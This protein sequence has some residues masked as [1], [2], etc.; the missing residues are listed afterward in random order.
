MW[1]KAAVCAILYGIDDDEE[2]AG[3]L[4][5]RLK[6]RDEDIVKAVTWKKNPGLPTQTGAFYGELGIRAVEA[7]SLLL[8]W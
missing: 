1:S 5:R 7:L 4:E 3:G 2:A 8:L 6:K